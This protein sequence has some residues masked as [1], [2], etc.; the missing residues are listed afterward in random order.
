MDII[1]F[2][3]EEEPDSPIVSGS[4]VVTRLE[5]GAIALDY[6]GYRV[7]LEPEDATTVAADVFLQGGNTAKTKVLSTVVQELGRWDSAEVERLW[8]KDTIDTGKANKQ[9]LYITCHDCEA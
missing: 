2:N 8:D 3:E 6:G 4:P 9:R 5:S 1:H 7:L